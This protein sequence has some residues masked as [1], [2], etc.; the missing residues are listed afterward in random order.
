[1]VEIR[2]TNY[3][4][5]SEFFPPKLTSFN[6]QLEQKEKQVFEKEIFD[7]ACFF[8]LGGSIYRFLNSTSTTRKIEKAKKILKSQ[9]I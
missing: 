2:S 1:M 4:H 7:F 8:L 9:L 5:Y 3:F 6:A